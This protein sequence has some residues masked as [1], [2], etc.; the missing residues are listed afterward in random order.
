[1]GRT[2]GTGGDFFFAIAAHEDFFTGAGAIGAG[3]LAD[4]AGAGGF[5]ATEEARASRKDVGAP[6]VTGLAAIVV[7]AS[8]AATDLPTSTFWCGTFCGFGCA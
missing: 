3:A 4:V 1:M 7:D 5:F 8:A 2:G 6:A